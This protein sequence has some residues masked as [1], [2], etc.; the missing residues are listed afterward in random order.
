MQMSQTFFFNSAFGHYWLKH[1]RIYVSEVSRLFILQHPS[2]K[3]ALSTMIAD[4]NNIVGDCWCIKYELVDVTLW[5]MTNRQ[6]SS[7]DLPSCSHCPT[8]FRL[9]SRAPICHHTSLDKFSFL[10]T[11]GHGTT[12]LASTWEHLD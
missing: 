4:S 5:S 6:M 10:R 3:S 11:A 8:P 12:T 2:V 9:C 1:G 7:H